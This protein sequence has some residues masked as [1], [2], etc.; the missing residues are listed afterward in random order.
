MEFWIGNDID[1]MEKHVITEPTIIRYAF[2]WHCPLIFKRSINRFT[3]RPML[4]KEDSGYFSADSTK[5]GT[6]IIPPERS[7]SEPVYM[8]SKSDAICADAVIRSYNTGERT[9][10]ETRPYIRLLILCGRS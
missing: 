6:P 7:D 9:L 10:E 4:T 1:N 8:M 3:L 5:T 2:T